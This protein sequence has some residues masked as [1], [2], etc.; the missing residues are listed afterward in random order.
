MRARGNRDRL[1]IAT[2]IG[3]S[4]DH[5]GLS[6]RAIEKAVDASLQRLRVSHIDLLY[7][8]IDDE[9]VPFDE[10]LLAV[11]E[12]IRDG[13]VRFFGGSHHTGNRLLEARIAS[14]QLGVA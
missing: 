9:S 2:K 14:G 3:K 12:L 6:A 8:H 11:D 4:A 7:L 13:R 10:T 5:P 1:T